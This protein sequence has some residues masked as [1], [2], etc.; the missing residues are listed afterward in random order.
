MSIDIGQ[1]GLVMNKK[2]RFKVGTGDELV[3]V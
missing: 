2:M 1:Q 3:V